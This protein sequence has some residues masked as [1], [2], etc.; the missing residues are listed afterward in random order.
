MHGGTGNQQYE[1]ARNF[2]L[3]FSLMGKATALHEA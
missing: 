2:H 1:Q 3:S